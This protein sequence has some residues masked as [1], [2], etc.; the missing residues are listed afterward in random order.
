MPGTL[1][2]IRHGQSLWN[3]DDRFCGWVDIKLSETGREQARHSAKLIL[4]SG[5]VQPDIC[6]TSRLSRAIESANIILEEMD[7]QYIDEVKSWRLNERHYGKLQGEPKSHI[8]ELYGKEQYQF[9][10]RAFKGCPP[11][12]DPGDKYYCIDDRRYARVAKNELPRA[13]SLQMVTKRLL[14]FYNKYVVPHLE[15]DETVLMVTHGSIV[16]ALVKHLYAIDDEAI[17]SVN[18]PNGIPMVI[19]FNS[20]MAPETEHFEFLDPERARIEAEK[21]ARQGFEKSK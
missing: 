3:K 13:E 20:V 8:L 17:S 19:K 14:P 12:V 18:I 15:A 16:R 4:E 6:F 10:R 9:W 1:I 7:C 21:V 2:L 5:Y 11:A